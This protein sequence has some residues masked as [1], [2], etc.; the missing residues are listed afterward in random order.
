MKN[1]ISLDHAKLHHAEFGQLIVRFFEDFGI[2][3]LDQNADPDF[4]KLFDVLQAQI[5]TYN[6]ALNQI[7]ANEE[8][9]KIAELDQERDA[10]LQSLRD[11]LKP[12]KNAKTQAEKDAYNALK[13]LINEYKGVEDDTYE[14]ETN[15]LNSLVNRLL[16]SDYSSHVATLGIVKF[17]NHL[18]DSN[19]AFN[20]LFSH[21]SYEVSQKVSYDVKT[22]RK[23]LREDYNTM[24]NYISTLAHVKEDSYYK[25]ILTIINNGRNYF[26][27][28]VVSR[29]TGNKNNVEKP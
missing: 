25:D 1:L 5:P 10:D 7:R 15:K 27:N 3:G 14:E 28:V 22:L 20:D 21:R 26:S 2:S 8:S 9:Q 6:N 24:T 18:A 4:K 12:Y 17:I 29:R 19:T 13:I 11:G 23:N 16:S